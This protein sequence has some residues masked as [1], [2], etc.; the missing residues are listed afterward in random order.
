MRERPFCSVTHK[1][2][3]LVFSSRFSR[4]YGNH[5]HSP[6]I[7][8]QG[9]PVHLDAHHIRVRLVVDLDLNLERQLERR[10]NRGGRCRRP[11]R[12]GLDCRG[13]SMV[14]YPPSARSLCAINRIYDWPRGRDGPARA[15]PAHHRNAETLRQCFFFFA[16]RCRTETHEPISH[17][18][19]SAL[20]RTL[21][22]QR[23]TRRIRHHRQRSIRRTRATSTSTAPPATYSPTDTHTAACQRF[24]GGFP[25]RGVS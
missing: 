24:E 25:W 19:F 23:R 6:H 12:C 5:F 1:H 3:H 9:L 14:H 17:H 10:R 4:G 8:N 7:V 22:I 20:S 13:R 21:R 16:V 11:H 15:L 18:T 2:I